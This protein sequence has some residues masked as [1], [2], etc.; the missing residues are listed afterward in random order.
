MSVIIYINH[1]AET[2]MVHDS[3]CSCV[4]TEKN[5]EIWDKYRNFTD[6]KEAEEWMN[7]MLNIAPYDYDYYKKCKLCNPK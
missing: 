4:S 2:A 3:K 7:D 1:N 6:N 5:L